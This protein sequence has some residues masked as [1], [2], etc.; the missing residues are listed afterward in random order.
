MLGALNTKKKKEKICI[1]ALCS[2]GVYHCGLMEL[3]QFKRCTPS[4]GTWESPGDLSLRQYSG[5][6]LFYSNRP[7]NHGEWLGGFSEKFVF[8]PWGEEFDK[9]S[10]PRKLNEPISRQL[11]A[12]RDIPVRECNT[13]MNGFCFEWG[14]C[15]WRDFGVFQGRTVRPIITEYDPKSRTARTELGDLVLV[16]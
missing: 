4:S 12:M 3:F 15:F 8:L 13:N 16:K 5:L 7:I 2:H 10:S 14:F 1:L 11:T 6:C 9:V